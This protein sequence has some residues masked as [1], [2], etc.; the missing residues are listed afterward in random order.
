MTEISG[1]DASL[2]DKYFRGKQ[3]ASAPHL[4]TLSC[5]ENGRHALR[6]A[7]MLQG[8]DEQSSLCRIWRKI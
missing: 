8:E 1:W 3:I 4:Q 6:A 5:A 7:P 2:K